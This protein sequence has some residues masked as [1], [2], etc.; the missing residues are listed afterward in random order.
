[1]HGSRCKFRVGSKMSR[2]DPKPLT[3]SVT[4]QLAPCNAGFR[5]GGMGLKV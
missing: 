4:G 2:G 1:M 5:F 3:V